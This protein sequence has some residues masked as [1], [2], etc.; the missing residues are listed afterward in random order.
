[1]PCHIC[2]TSSAAPTTRLNCRARTFAPV[3]V[4]FSKPLI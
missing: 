1:L 4:E 2:Q 3:T